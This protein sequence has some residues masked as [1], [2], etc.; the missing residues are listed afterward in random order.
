MAIFLES[1][2]QKSDEG[3]ARVKRSLAGRTVQ[4]STSLRRQALLDHL[5]IYCAARSQF[6]PPAPAGPPGK[7]GPLGPPGRPGPLG[8]P[9]RP[10]FLGPPGRPGSMGPPGRPGSLGPPGS[11]GPKGN[12]GQR[13]Q[14]GKKG[15]RGIMGLQ[16]PPGRP[17]SKGPLGIKGKNGPR[18]M[19]GPRGP[20]GRPGQSA[21]APDVIIS[22]PSLTV[23]ETDSAAFYCSATGNPRPVI[24][25]RK[26]NGSVAK[27]RSD[28][29]SSGRLV[30]NGSLFS[31]RGIYKCQAR[32]ILGMAQTET[33]LVV[34]GK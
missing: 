31:D 4:N 12:D 28:T 8:Q 22:P 24:V 16:G 11:P 21:A 1:H 10:G 30:I 19:P 26:L 29:T 32:N 13:G 5:E 34:N 7:P 27:Y 15:P 17:G 6:C 3:I 2:N 20:S 33:S 14:A 9:G 25:W 23:N 18:G